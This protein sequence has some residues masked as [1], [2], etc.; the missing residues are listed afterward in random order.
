[1]LRN[2][3]GYQFNARD[4]RTR[5]NV[6]IRLDYTLSTKNSFSVTGIYTATFWTVRTKTPPST[7]FPM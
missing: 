2:T 4:N 3:A 6:T 5:D 1:M 7:P